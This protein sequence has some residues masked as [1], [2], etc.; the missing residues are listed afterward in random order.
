VT[1]LH[2]PIP[3]PPGLRTSSGNSAEAMGDPETPIR[4]GAGLSKAQRKE[5]G[6]IGR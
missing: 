1:I 6:K 3:H 5:L 2:A 4:K